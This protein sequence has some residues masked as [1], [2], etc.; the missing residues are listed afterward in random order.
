MSFYIFYETATIMSY[1]GNWEHC[2]NNDN[3]RNLNTLGPA[4]RVAEHKFVIVIGKINNDL[5]KIS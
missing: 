2:L 4:R 1:I 3:S 5:Q